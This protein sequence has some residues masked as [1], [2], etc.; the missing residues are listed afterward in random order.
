MRLQRCILILFLVFLSVAQGQNY[1]TSNKKAIKLYERGMEVL[2]QGKNDAAMNSFEQALAE[3]NGFLEAHLML[4]DLMSDI[5]RNKMELVGKPERQYRDKAK[6]HY[7]AVVD[8]RHD[9]FPPA[10]V[11]LGKLELY[12]KNYDEAI[13]CFETFISLDKKETMYSMFWQ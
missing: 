9:F 5:D 13:K 6:S 7:R 12:D 10:W 4:G 2:Y 11:S 8:S 1:S 3:D